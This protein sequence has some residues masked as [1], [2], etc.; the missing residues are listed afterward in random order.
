MGKAYHVSD[1]IGFDGKHYYC[2][3]CGRSG[4]ERMTQARGHL[5]QCPE[6]IPK[7]R[8]IRL[9]HTVQEL[10]GTFSDSQGI[11]HAFGLRFWPL[12]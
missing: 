10:T 4:Y 1:H 5:G 9:N 6:K 3:H 2:L 11:V 7:P 8:V 12:K